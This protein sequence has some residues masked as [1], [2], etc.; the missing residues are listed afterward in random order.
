MSGGVGAVVSDRRRKWVFLPCTPP[1]CS[2]AHLHTCTLAVLHTCTLAHHHLLCSACSTPT[3][4]PLWGCNKCTL[5]H[6]LLLQGG[7]QCAMHIAHHYLLLPSLRL[8]CSEHHF[9]SRLHTDLC[10]KTAFLYLRKIFWITS[11][12]RRCV[13]VNITIHIISLNTKMEI[14][15]HTILGL[16]TFPL[17]PFFRPFKSGPST[18]LH[19][20]GGNGSAIA[21]PALCQILYLKYFNENLSKWW[22]SLLLD[23]TNVF[24]VTLSHCILI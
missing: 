23:S 6:Q 5:V 9:P 14:A 19:R 2:L 17:S 13:N 3:P 8:Q 4:P 11:A 1:P 18:P 7:A 21:Q 24:F 22:L 15:I 12:H 10:W 20:K 16:P